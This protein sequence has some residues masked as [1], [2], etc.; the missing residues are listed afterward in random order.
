MTA[1]A[2]HGALQFFD[3]FSSCW[4]DAVCE[5]SDSFNRDIAYAKTQDQSQKSKTF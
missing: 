1:D 5:I 4:M 2:F 3:L